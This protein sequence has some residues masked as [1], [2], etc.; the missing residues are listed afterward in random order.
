[1]KQFFAATLFLFFAVYA[2]AA[3]SPGISVYVP[4]VSGSAGTPGDI[5]FFSA[6]LIRELV[7][8][9]YYPERSLGTADYILQGNLTH[10]EGTMPER[11]AEERLFSFHLLLS[12]S[13]SGKAVAEQTIIYGGSSREELSALL[14]AAVAA[15]LP[16]VVPA[17][18]PGDD[19]RRKTWYIGSAVL[20]KP[21]IYFGTSYAGNIVNFGGSVLAEF[22]FHDFLSLE[23]G[24]EAAP[25]WIAASS[26][27]GD[28]YWGVVM[29][30]P[31]N[32]KAAFKP[33]SLFM[34][35]PYG[36]VHVNIPLYG[37]IDPP[38]FSW[39]IGLQYGI[40]AGPGVFFIEPR[41]SMDFGKSSLETRSGR[42]LQYSRYMIHLGLGYKFGIK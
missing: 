11:S 7:E 2:L 19:W 1:M 22:H 3:Q 21:S 9:N 23:T 15:L 34:I 27:P 32:L 10:F 25:H 38:L 42:T 39:R 17:A 31:L 5:A 4:P 20:W 6:Q 18:A 24:A 29:E 30:I 13:G 26:T 8:R 33:G 37:A 12:E 28:N 36:G 14:S 16:G 40:K 41:F 35:E